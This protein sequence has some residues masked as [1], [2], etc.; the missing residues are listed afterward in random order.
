M[1]DLFV[2]GEDQMIYR[3]SPEVIIGVDS[4]LAKIA[5][6]GFATAERVCQFPVAAGCRNGE[7]QWSD[8]FF[9]ISITPNKDTVF[10]AAIPGLMFDCYFQLN[11]EYG[12]NRLV[13]CLDRNTDYRQTASTFPDKLYWGA[14][15]VSQGSLESLK[16]ILAVVVP[17]GGTN[18]RNMTVYLTF[19]R[20]NPHDDKISGNYLPIMPNIF[21]D[22]KVCMGHGWEPH[23][24]G[25]ESIGYSIKWFFESKMN[26][27]LAQDTVDRPALARRFFGWDSNKSTAKSSDPVGALVTKKIGNYYLDG[28]P[29]L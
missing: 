5:N 20:K 10:W 28:L 22:G 1:K 26:Y 29:S 7:I 19:Q 12:V 23:F 27:D 6:Q 18:N 8:C 3:Y 16:V 21:S 15:A 17:H 13:P 25:T 4:I 24:G 2:I 11:S 9:N 14:N